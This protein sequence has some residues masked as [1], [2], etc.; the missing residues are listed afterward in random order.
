MMHLSRKF[1]GTIGVGVAAALIVVAT[2]GSAASQDNTFSILP[3]TF[4]VDQLPLQLLANDLKR[5]EERDSTSGSSPSSN[6]TATTTA[7]A[8]TTY[9]PSS[10]VTERVEAQYIAFIRGIAPADAEIVRSDLARFD[11]PDAWS[12]IVS[13]TDF[14]S[15]DASDAMASYWILN[16]MIANNETADRPDD[17]ARAAAVKRQV[18]GIIA[19]NPTFASMNDAQKQEMAE[20][21]MLNFIYQHKSF[22]E[23]ARTNDSAMQGRLA[24]AAVARF[25]NEMGVDLR[26]IHLTDQGFVSRN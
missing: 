24:D 6:V 18:G 10:A 8:S 7:V 21:L 12:Q 11:A 14:R 17:R 9:S 4:W 19:G 22:S 5:R 26:A 1:F 16:W 15:G 2:S 25:R 20:A 23:A 13:R 3:S